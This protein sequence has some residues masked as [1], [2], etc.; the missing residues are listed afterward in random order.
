MCVLPIDFHFKFCILGTSIL[1][2]KLDFFKE[3]TG[4][5]KDSEVVNTHKS[6]P[7]KYSGSSPTKVNF[8][9]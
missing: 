5:D 4:C 3:A 1:P 9:Y 7:E 2:P 8:L 6:T